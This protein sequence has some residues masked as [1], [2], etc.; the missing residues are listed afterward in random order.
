MRG[1]RTGHQNTIMTQVV[2][3]IV[4]QISQAA[5]IAHFWAQTNARM[6]SAQHPWER[7]RDTTRRLTTNG[8][9]RSSGYDE[10]ERF[11]NQ[12]LNDMED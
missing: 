9:R 1:H 12:Y 8:P 5:M 10:C 11:D 2:L 4:Y 6:V 7:T 3:V